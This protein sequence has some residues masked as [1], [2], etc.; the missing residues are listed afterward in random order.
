[1]PVRSESFKSGV[2]SGVDLTKSISKEDYK[3]EIDR[4]QKKLEF[5][6]SQITH[7]DSGCAGI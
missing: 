4:L 7:A 3:K 6:H 1:M 2:L 5:L